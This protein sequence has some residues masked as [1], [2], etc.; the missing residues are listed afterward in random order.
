MYFVA[1]LYNYESHNEEGSPWNA[2]DAIH[3]LVN[4]ERD[5]SRVRGRGT[6]LNTSQIA[7]FTFLSTKS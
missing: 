1:K 3:K 7:S 2:S 4:G 6:S 5:Y